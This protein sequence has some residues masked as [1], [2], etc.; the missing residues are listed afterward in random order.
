MARAL[1]K[2]TMTERGMK[3]ISRAAPIRARTTWKTPARI[4]AAM[5]WSMPWEATSG[6]ITSATA[7]VAAEIIAGRPP[8]TAV[9][10]AMVKDANR[11]R[12]GSTPAMIEKAIASGMS[13][14]ATTSPARTSVLR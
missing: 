2:P 7:P 6:A 8:S 3:R 13:A 1:T 4:T 12:R 14:R 5:K 9:V 10:T 11:P